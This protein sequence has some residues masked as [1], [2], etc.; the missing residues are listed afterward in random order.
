LPLS[1]S[2]PAGQAITD[3]FLDKDFQINPID[4]IVLIHAKANSITLII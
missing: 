1:F 3:L 4:D 2:Q